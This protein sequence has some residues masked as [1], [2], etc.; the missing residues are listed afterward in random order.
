MQHNK[1]N[2]NHGDNVEERVKNY[3]AMNGIYS[4][5]M[6]VNDLKRK[7]NLAEQGQNH[8]S[9]RCNEVLEPIDTSSM[10]SEGTT[11]THGDDWRYR[12]LQ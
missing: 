7:E 5:R 12:G 8:D 6:S 10:T 3:T 9:L 1:S 11:T 4:F 2:G